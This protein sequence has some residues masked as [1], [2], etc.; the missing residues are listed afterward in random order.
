M[1]QS[2]KGMRGMVS[3]SHHLAAQ[4]GLNVLRDGGNAI[5]AMVAAAATI[6]VVY[7]HMNGLGGDGFWLISTPEQRVPRAINAVGAAGAAVDEEF[8][9]RHGLD[10]VPIRGPLAANT[11]VGTIS[12]WM[13]ALE[14][15]A[16]WGGRMPLERLLEEA[17][18]YAREGC[19]VTETQYRNTSA[20]KDVLI[21]VPGWADTFLIDGVVP[22]TGALFKQPALAKTLERLATA[23]L[24]DF[25]RGE[26]ARAL[27]A[28]LAR[29]GSPITADDLAR[30]Q[31]VE[32]EPLAVKLGP[33]TAYNVT[34]P[35][36]GVT[37]LIILGLFDRLDC[38]EAEGFDHVHGAVEASK[39]AILTRNRFVT[40]PVYMT[41]SPQDFLSD[42]AL[43]EMAGQIDK[44]RAMAWPAP[45]VPGDTVWLG[46]VD[47]EG[48][49]ISFIHSIY[50]EFGSGVVLRDTGV[51]WQNRGSSF[52]LNS[53]E[54]NYVL[55][56]RLPFHTN[57]PALALL[58]DG[59]V[60]VY[61]AMGGEGQPQSQAAVFTRYA[62]FGQS[63]QQ[64]ITAPR[65][66]LSR[67][68]GAPRTDLRVES[69][70]SDEVVA[71]L[72]TAGHEVTVVGDFDD[73]MGHAG[74]IVL[75]PSGLMEG[76]N[77][78]RCDGVA[79]AF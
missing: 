38:A 28:D 78:P 77:D 23:G 16:G 27:G 13:A 4:A 41:R 62:Y 10:T 9:R 64:A 39:H 72:R 3:S 71:A 30:Q 50:W 12:G 36:Q 65:W 58:N 34:P 61:G 2:A 42:R 29:A 31:A 26:L 14:I 54:Q 52:S 17:I 56:G 20:K 68:W 33:G 8:Y 18:Y 22:A 67:T 51:Q 19:L 55:P 21:D 60:M 24:D 76:G 70:F 40:D 6:S 37:S 45:S 75:H 48:R 35:S 5:E 46:A 7:P 1:L 47:G 15:S 32:T 11:S 44:N 66:V 25:Y 73:V 53:D 69:R 79:A 49:A 74:A 57:N 59:R 63:V 43:D